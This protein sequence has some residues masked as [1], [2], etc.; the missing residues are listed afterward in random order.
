VVIG[1]G[2]KNAELGFSLLFARGLMLTTMTK[3]T[4]GDPRALTL[5]V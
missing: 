5:G 3:T 2:G 1:S 4:S